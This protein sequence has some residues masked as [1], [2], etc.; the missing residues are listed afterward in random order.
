MAGVGVY[1]QAGSLLAFT[2]ASMYYVYVWGCATDTHLPPVTLD[3]PLNVFVRLDTMTS[4]KEIASRLTKPATV[5]SQA[6]MKSYLSA[7]VRI[8]GRFGEQ[9]RMLLGN[10]QNRAL[11]C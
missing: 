6:T 8:R 9:R 1:D 11:I 4:T 2:C 7:R 3:V 10:S 5:S